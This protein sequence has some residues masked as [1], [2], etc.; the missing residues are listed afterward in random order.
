MVRIDTGICMFCNKPGHIELTD[1]QFARYSNK[2]HGDHIQDVLP[3]VSI[4]DREMLI[5]GSH[6][7]C[8]DKMFAEEE[9]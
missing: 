9:D 4:A 8:F 3:D 1:E 2:R 7:E 5:T 6:S